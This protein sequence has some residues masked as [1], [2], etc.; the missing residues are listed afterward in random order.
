M[1]IAV[2]LTIRYRRGTVR[3]F[4][5]IELRAYLVFVCIEF[6]VISI[7]KALEAVMPPSGGVRLIISQLIEMTYF[8][9]MNDMQQVPHVNENCMLVSQPTFIQPK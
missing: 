9:P 2:S 4:H 6:S 8:V 7:A 3:K 1:E 5:G